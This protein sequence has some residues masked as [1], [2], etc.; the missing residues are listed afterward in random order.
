MRLLTLTDI[1][2]VR[3]KNE[4]ALIVLGKSIAG[5]GTLSLVVTGSRFQAAC[6]VIAPP[7]IAI[8]IDGMGGMGAGDVAA[9]YA[10]TMFAR[11]IG[12]RYGHD[13][14]RLAVELRAVFRVTHRHLLSTGRSTAG[15]ATMGAALA[16]FAIDVRGRYLVFHAGDAR[17]Y[18]IRRRYL[19]PLT[20]DHAAGPQGGLTN[21]LGGGLPP[22]AVRLEIGEPSGNFLEPGQALLAVSDGFYN[23]LDPGLI[24]TALNGDRA[25]MGALDG[26]AAAIRQKGADD[27]F[28]AIIVR[29]ATD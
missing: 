20:V 29:H 24:E 25:D 22:E 7:L 28:S 18:R 10:A 27:N 5:P 23:N 26:F 4:D 14:G 1:G 3:K 21:C 2:L 17:V 13:L 8:A 19:E 12:P 16:G 9:R 15:Q 11:I 6:G